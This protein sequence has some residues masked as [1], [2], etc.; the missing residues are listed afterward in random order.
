[1]QLR[2]GLLVFALVLSALSLGAALAPPPKDDEEPATTAARPRT[3]APGPTAIELRQPAP[4]VPPVRRVRTG[5]HIV[6]RVS[7]RQSGS[8]EIP[9]LG[10]LQPVEPGTPALFDLLASRP[11]R[12]DVNLVATGAERTKLGTL[13]VEG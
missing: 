12:Y 8:V 6:L 1:M 13:V 7:A 2:R 3:P 4:E 9:G 5:A 11:G 10:L